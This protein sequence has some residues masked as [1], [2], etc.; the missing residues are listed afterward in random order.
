MM[1]NCT[2]TRKRRRTPQT[3]VNK[4]YTFIKRARVRLAEIREMGG[5][6]RENKGEEKEKVIEQ[7]ER[8]RRM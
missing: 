8:W 2:G 6:G 1:S 5:E 3:K 7:R 4:S